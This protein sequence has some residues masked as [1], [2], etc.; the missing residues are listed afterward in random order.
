MCVCELKTGV[1]Q[2]APLLITALVLLYT[3]CSY[4]MYTQQLHSYVNY[5][6]KKLFKNILNIDIFSKLQ[7]SNIARFFIILGKSENINWGK[8]KGQSNV[9]FCHQCPPRPT[10]PTSERPIKLL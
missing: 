3:L 6:N 7:Y 1:Y 2:T 8:G 9:L 5:M 4:K 10:L